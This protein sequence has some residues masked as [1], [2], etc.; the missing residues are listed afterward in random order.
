METLTLKQWFQDN[1]PKNERFERVAAYAC[2]YQKGMNGTDIAK[3]LNETN[4]YVYKVFRL[5][6]VKRRTMKSKVLEYVNEYLNCDMTAHDIAR[7]CNCS[8]YRV[9]QIIGK[10]GF[11]CIKTHQ[12]KASTTLVK[13]LSNAYEN[14][15]ISFDELIEKTGINPNTLRSKLSY[16]GIKRKKRWQILEEFGQDEFMKRCGVSIEYLPTLISR[17]KW[18]GKL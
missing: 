16:Y 13:K 6:G 4:D 11:S 17:W 7:R 5:L 1:K 12:D 15:L 18:E 14:W 8:S 10:A 9:Y 3:E 2:E